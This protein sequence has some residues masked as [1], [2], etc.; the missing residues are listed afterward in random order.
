[1]RSSISI[2][3]LYE[4]NKGFLYHYNDSYA[5]LVCCR[6]VRKAG[7]EHILTTSPVLSEVQYW[8]R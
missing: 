8:G 5:T 7:Y 6:S 2:S 3:S 4:R 1:M